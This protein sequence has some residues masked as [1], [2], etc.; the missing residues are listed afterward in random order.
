M[1]TGFVDD[2]GNARGRP[3][4]V[5]VGKDGA[6]L[7]A[8]DVGNV[9]WRV[10]G[11]GP[12]NRVSRTKSGAAHVQLAVVL[13]ALGAVVGLSMAVQHFRGRTPPSPAL[14]ILHGAAGRYPA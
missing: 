12:D 4:G 7:V 8:D 5:V 1:L 2:D 6:L 14:A 13:I 11:S 10:A 9:V 3:V